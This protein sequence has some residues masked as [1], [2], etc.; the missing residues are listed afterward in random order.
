ME[1]PHEVESPELES[2]DGQFTLPHWQMKVLLDV[3]EDE[4][5]SVTRRLKDAKPGDEP[6][7]HLMERKAA[8]AAFVSELKDALGVER[9]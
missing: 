8:L 9:D 6:M 7:A 5:K 4:L 3:N 1:W 2:Q